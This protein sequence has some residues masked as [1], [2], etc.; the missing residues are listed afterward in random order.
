MINIDKE[1]LIEL[2]LPMV[3]IVFSWIAVAGVTVAGVWLSLSYENWSI[4]ARCGSVV[5]VIALLLAVYDHF[6]WARSLSQ[7]A[8]SVAKQKESG[9][10]FVK[11]IREGLG[12]HGVEKSENE[13][14][15]LAEQK[16]KSYHENFPYR[17]SYHMKSVF[18]KNELLIGVYGTMVWG[19]GDL[20]GKLI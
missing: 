19:F 14:S 16:S 2:A 4:F 12:S 17:Y 11:D 1:D 8:Q 20:I 9:D 18:Q 10:T 13:I 3:A 5:V 15:F 6:S 7:L